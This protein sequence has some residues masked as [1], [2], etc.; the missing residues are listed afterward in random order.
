MCQDR[1]VARC[2]IKTQFARRLGGIH[3]MFRQ[4]SCTVRT[5]FRIR[6]VRNLLCLDVT[7]NG[8]FRFA[9]VE[10]SLLDSR[11]RTFFA[12][13]SRYIRARLLNG[14]AQILASIQGGA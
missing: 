12:L 2:E 13:P 4:Y 8:W 14:I 9:R 11:G 3:Q 10:H 5:D 6:E 1:A 7:N